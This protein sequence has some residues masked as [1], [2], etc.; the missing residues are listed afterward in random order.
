MDK[1]GLGKAL[2]LRLVEDLVYQA[3]LLHDCEGVVREGVMVHARMIKLVITLQ[4][5]SYLITAT[6][7]L[8]LLKVSFFTDVFK[9]AEIFALSLFQG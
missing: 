3:S 7:S 8:F 6:D 9:L 4:F 1:K 5:S 2:R